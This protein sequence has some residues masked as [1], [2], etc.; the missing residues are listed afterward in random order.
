MTLTDAIKKIVK[1]IP[2][3]NERVRIAV[4]YSSEDYS[5]DIEELWV[6]KLGD[7]IWRYAS[8]CSCWDG[9]YTEDTLPTIKEFRVQ[10]DKTWEDAVYKFAETGE[11]QDLA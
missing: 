10:C 9:D 7:F 5:V 11:E 4:K 2:K 8:G 3:D 6:D 1:R